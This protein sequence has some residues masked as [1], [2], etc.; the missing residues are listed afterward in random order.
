VETME[1]HEFNEVLETMKKTLPMVQK[2]FPID[3][4]FGITD[5]EKFVYY[6]PGKEID[7]KLPVGAAIPP[8]AGFKKILRSGEPTLS[9]VPKEIYGVPFKSSSM[10]I[11]DKVGK[12]VGVITMGISL[13]NQEILSSAAQSLAATSEEVIATTEE[14]A[15]TATGLAQMIN[16]LKVTGHSVVQELHKTDEILGFIRSVAAN[17][18]LLGLNA[19]IEAARAGEHGRGF[20]V[21]AEEIRKMAVTSADST[22]DI[23][24]ILL[25][26]RNDIMAIDEKLAACSAQS[27]H[28]AIATE[29]IASAIQQMVSSITD[30]EKI[31]R[32]I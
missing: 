13:K 25:N 15:T 23:T 16:N 1:N 14:I 5:E 30:L 6:L 29:Q 4:M 20:A 12:T 27:E 17:S 2:L 28:Q 18:N 32:L 10:P 24:K 31:S 22:Q 19:A 21:V 11:K 7:I 8:G 3:V 9:N 26:I